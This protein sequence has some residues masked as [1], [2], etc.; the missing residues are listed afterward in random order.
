MYLSIYLSIY[1][2]TLFIFAIINCY[3]LY[4]HIILL[5][6]ISFTDV[7]VS[8]TNH[9]FKRDNHNE[10]K[11]MQ[12]FCVIPAIASYILLF[13]TTVQLINSYLSNFSSFLFH[14][15]KFF[16]FIFVYLFLN[17]IILFYFSCLF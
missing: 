11:A 9:F 6:V 13:N 1:I 8:Q 2:R 3:H 17:F 16:S 7:Y 15:C 14:F 4:H 5:N 12:F 10:N